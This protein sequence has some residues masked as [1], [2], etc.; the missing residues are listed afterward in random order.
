MINEIILSDAG[1]EFFKKFCKGGNKKIMESWLPKI[2][3]NY[4]NGL[5][6]WESI[7]SVCGSSHLTFF[8]ELKG[9]KK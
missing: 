4:K 9:G 1:K 6:Y 2:N 3:E 7:I 5:T 8:K